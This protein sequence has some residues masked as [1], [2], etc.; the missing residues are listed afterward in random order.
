MSCA[1]RLS[2][3]R[4]RASRGAFERLWADMAVVDLG[5]GLVDEAAALARKHA[6]RA[7]DA[8]HLASAAALRDAVPVEFACFDRDLRVAAGR[9][10]LAVLPEA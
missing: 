3:A 8:V 2:T 1:R 4:L 6:L 10:R 9:E 7:Y 5:A